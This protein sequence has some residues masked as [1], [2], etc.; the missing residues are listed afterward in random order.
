MT[1]IQKDFKVF[2]FNRGNKFSCLVVINGDHV[3]FEQIKYPDA[4]TDLVIDKFLDDAEKYAKEC[5][6]NV[7]G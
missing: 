2:E 7:K 1:K 5:L 3:V 4:T 6:S